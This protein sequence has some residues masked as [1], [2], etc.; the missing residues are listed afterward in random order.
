VRPGRAETRVRT[1]QQKTGVTVTATSLAL[2]QEPPMIMCCPDSLTSDKLA[3][4][5]TSEKPKPSP[6]VLRMLALHRP[7]GPGFLN[8]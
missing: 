7:L 5:S 2:R 3:W 1:V 4:A 6:Y 8:L